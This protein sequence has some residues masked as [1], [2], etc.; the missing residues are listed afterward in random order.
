MSYRYAIIGGGDF[1][2]E[3]A[4]YLRDIW[5]SEKLGANSVTDI[6]STGPVRVASFISI[7]G[8]PP[9]VVDCISAVPEFEEKLLVVAIGDPG[10]RYRI[11]QEIDAR[12]G[13]LGSV[14]HPTAYVASTAS[15]EG[16]AIVCPMSFVGP[17]ARIG[18]NCAINV[19]AIVGHD[20]TLG[21]CTV[22]SPGSKVGGRGVVCEGG[23]LGSG[24]I[25][26][27]GSSLGAFSKLSA[28]SVLTGSAGEGF[29]M[30]GNPAS[31]RK[32]FRRP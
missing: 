10:V 30:H 3:V 28:G 5:A 21:D 8:R 9:S 7:L 22:M 26:T 12:R 16:G 32:M 31:G 2:V 20:V 15:L 29:L 14:I 4:G 23:F 6:V 27:P 25:V 18:R 11:M 13:R 24:A 19:H 1:A 17:F